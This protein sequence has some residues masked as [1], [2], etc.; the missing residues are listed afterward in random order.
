MKASNEKL[1][2]RRMSVRPNYDCSSPEGNVLVYY[3]KNNQKKIIIFIRYDK[4]K[5]IGLLFF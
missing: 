1:S 4:I 2:Q 3:T 5:N